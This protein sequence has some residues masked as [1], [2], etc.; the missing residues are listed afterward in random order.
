[1]TV[2]YSVVVASVHAPVTAEIARPEEVAERFQ[3]VCNEK[4][5]EGWRLVNSEPLHESRI[6]MGWYLF[7]ERE[8]KVSSDAR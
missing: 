6:E 2:E 8:K 7:F 4:A 3:L 5:D 1:M